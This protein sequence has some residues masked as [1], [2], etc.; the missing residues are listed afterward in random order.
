M[1]EQ[2]PIIERLLTKREADDRL[3]LGVVD[4][5]RVLGLG[6]RTVWRLSGSGELPAPLKI[7]GRRL[8]HRPTLE[9]FLSEQVESEGGPR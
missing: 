8:W 2:T 7:G 1:T 6:E 3:L 4:V 9:K 5:A